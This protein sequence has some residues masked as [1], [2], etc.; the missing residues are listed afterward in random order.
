MLVYPE[1]NFKGFRSADSVQSHWQA[2]GQ[3]FLPTYL[4]QK[5]CLL[6]QD[7]FADIAETIIPLTIY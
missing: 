3:I 5:K 6:Q 7:V 1:Y 2:E 4:I